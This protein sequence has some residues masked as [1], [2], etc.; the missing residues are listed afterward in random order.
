MGVTQVRKRSGDLV[1]FNQEKVVQVIW[2]AMQS[3]GEGKKRDARD[4]AEEV[5][6]RLDKKFKDKIPGVEDIQDIV[7]Q[8]LMD[9]K[10]NRIAKHYILYRNERSKLREQKAALIGGKI[11]ELKLSFNAVK[12]LERRYLRRDEKGNITETPSDL[13]WRVANHVAMAE[14]RYGNDPKKNARRFFDMMANLHFLP[15]SPVLM[16]AGTE[17]QL[18]SCYVLPIEDSLESIFSTLQQ[19]TLIQKMG[20]GTGFSFSRIRPRGRTVAGITSVA[21]GP[22]AFLILYGKAMEM[23]KQSGR[24]SGANMAI[25]R[26]DHPDIL[27]FVNMKLVPGRLTNF[28]LSVAVTDDFMSALKDDK[29]YDLVSPLTRKPVGKLSARM[30][31]DSILSV[32][33]RTGDPGLLF[34][35]RINEN[36]PTPSLGD[37]EATS[38]CAE[39]PLLPHES[40]MQ[41]SINLTAFIKKKE[42]DWKGLKEVINNSVR[43]LDNCIDVNN[44]P[45]EEA[46][47]M[48][49]TTR[50]IGLGVMGFAD[51]LYRLG[52]PYD[53]KE[54]VD[55]A[56]ELSSFLTIEAE[57][58]SLELA[59]E[60]G[61]YDA[62]RNSLHEKNSK[63]RRNS[64]VTA[65]SPTGSVS[66]LAD[67]SAGIE[68]NWA[69]AY[70]RTVAGG[71]ELLL[72]NEALEE[73]GLAK[74]VLSTI[75]KRGHIEATDKVPDDLR[76][77]FK[78]AGQIDPSWHIKVQSAWQKNIEGAISKTINYPRNAGVQQLEKGM[79]MAWK[80][81]CKGITVYRDGS[82]E[83]QVL[84]RGT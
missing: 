21:G 61:T 58:A 66:L 43:F 76:R 42:V 72:V 1:L 67:V 57:K 39:Q 50:K 60:R 34:M 15:S 13:F 78:T 44:Y 79:L 14:V 68:P 80:L 49:K 55:L 20:G 40:S 9:L 74:E 18:S 45:V 5:S 75:S 52:I 63:P 53:S 7:E 82:H 35:D 77:V 47:A 2:K 22:L 81:G 48:A 30:V 11:D 28:N 73:A 27:D 25:L 51:L 41:G 3:T 33:W 31:F 12:L 62:Y 59:K 17:R 71:G 19:A 8:S 32:A 69:L 46:E 24:R 56:K 84:V 54:S 83:E 6:N 36:N 26:V 64:V 37:I 4:I 70:T 16:N 29:E 65:V 23:V 38:A 10:W